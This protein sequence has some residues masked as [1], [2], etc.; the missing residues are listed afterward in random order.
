MV[1]VT[2]SVQASNPF[3]GQ[4]AHARQRQTL[5]SL[6]SS[7]TLKTASLL[8][9]WLTTCGLGTV[10]KHK[11]DCGFGTIL[12]WLEVT[13]TGTFPNPTMEEETN[14]VLLSGGM[15]EEEQVGTTGSVIRLIYPGVSAREANET[16]FSC[17]FALGNQWN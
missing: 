15:F 2:I 5:T 7:Q 1:H 10:T 12:G 4:S 17:T 8:D 9:C 11:R 16:L 3:Q 6:K 13:P 14:I